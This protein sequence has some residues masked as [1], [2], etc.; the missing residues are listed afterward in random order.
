MKRSARIAVIALL[1]CFGFT[2]AHPFHSRAGIP[3][4][5]ETSVDIYADP[6]GSCTSADLV[7]RSPAGDE[8]LV[9]AVTVRDEFSVPVT[10]CSLRLDF[11]GSFSVHQELDPGVHPFKGYL[12][13]PSGVL[14]L[15]DSLGRAEFRIDRGGGC[16]ALVLDAIVTATCENPEIELASLSD[17]FCVRSTDM[18]GDGVA[19]FLDFFDYLPQVDTGYNW[20]GDFNCVAPVNSFDSFLIL[21]D[22]HNGFYSDEI[23]PLTPSTLPTCSGPLGKRGAREKSSRAFDGKIG[24]D[25]NG[26]LDCD[27]PDDMGTNYALPGVRDTVT[28]VLEGVPGIYAVGC[29]LCVL[30]SNTIDP[31]SVAFERSVPWATSRLREPILAIE[32]DPSIYSTYPNAKCWITSLVELGFIGDTVTALGEFSYDVAESGCV[33]F[34]IDGSH[35]AVLLTDYKREYFGGPLSNGGTTCAPFVCANP[36]DVLETD[37]GGGEVGDA[38]PTRARLSAAQPNPFNPSTTIRFTLTEPGEVEL[39]IRDLAGR[40]VKTLVSGRFGTG[41]HHISW[42]GTSEAGDEAV[43]GI[44]FVHMKNASFSET[45]KITLLR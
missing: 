36:T 2:I 44:Y 37:R 15:T 23:V 43:S 42:N 39:T 14:A 3:S 34:V 4:P 10:A 40:F 45:Q 17:T 12:G 9:I 13:G 25:R 11:S 38:A 22:V 16:G 29:V 20:C 6:Q 30:D 18:N 21:P 33:G 8:A 1:I 24:L 41:V 28:I 27:D 7:W 5:A 31:Q 35:S 26:D 19:N 32:V